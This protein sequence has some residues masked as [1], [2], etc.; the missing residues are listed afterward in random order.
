MNNLFEIKFTYPA[1]VN[2]KDK[3]LSGKV[4]ISGSELTMSAVA[5]SQLLERYFPST[6]FTNE[7]TDESTGGFKRINN[8][9]IIGASKVSYDYIKTFDGENAVWYAAK[10]VELIEEKKVSTIFVVL[11]NPNNIYNEVKAEFYDATTMQYREFV[12]DSH[13]PLN[14]LELL[15]INDSVIPYFESKEVEDVE[16]E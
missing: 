3:V 13:K 2:G 14:W 8:F 9:E 10:C 15:N 4:G 11:G 16:G 5:V 7:F 12:I 6:E 1:N